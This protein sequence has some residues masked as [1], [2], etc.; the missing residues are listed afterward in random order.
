MRRVCSCGEQNRPRCSTT[1]EWVWS[2]YCWYSWKQQVGSGLEL[3]CA[4]RT[5][6]YSEFM[7]WKNITVSILPKAIY[8]FNAVLIKIPMIFSTKLEETILKFIWNHRRLRIARA[9]LGKRTQLEISQL[10][11]YRLFYKVSVIKIVFY[12]NKN[13]Y[14]N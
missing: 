7:D 1:S 3:W 5:Q 8:R 13:R 14:I 12:W 6:R 10:P 4:W 9:V 11:D 2:S